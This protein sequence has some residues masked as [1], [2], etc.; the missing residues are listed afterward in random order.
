MKKVIISII[1]LHLV[2][3]GQA[4]QIIGLTN[5]KFKTGDNLEWSKPDYNDVSW[6]TIQAGINWEAEGYAGYDG[7]AWYRIKFYLPSKMK[8]NVLFKDSLMFLLGKIDDRDQTFLNGNIIGQNAKLIRT[9]KNSILQ[10]LSGLESAWDVSRK[11]S[12]STNDVRLKWD[13][14]NVLA[15][16]VHDGG[17][18]GGMYSLPVNIRMENLNDNL[19]FDIE[20]NSLQVKPDGTFNKT[21]TLKNR[22]SLPEIKG[23]L[24]MEITNQDTKKV[25]T[26]QILSVFLKK[27]EVAFTVNFKG[28]RSQRLKASYTFIESKNK[29]SVIHTQKFPYI[30]TPKESETPKINGTKVV[31]VRPG[32]PF[33]YRIPATGIKPMTFTVENLPE[34]LFLETDK[35]IITGNIKQKGDYLIKLKAV[36]TKGETTRN[37]KIVVGDRIALT[38]PMGWNSWNCFGLTVDEEKVK[39]TADIFLKTG[40]ADHGWTYINIDDG[41]EASQ[42]NG[43]GNIAPNGKFKNMKALTDYIH[44]YGLKAGLY[45]SP[46]P[47]TCGN[48]LGSYQHEESDAKMY[49]DWGF[50][51][52]KYDWCSYD[53]IAEDR[54]LIELQK[55]YK[56][57]QLALEKTNRD[58]LFSLCQY[59]MGD[60]WSW[61]DK[62]GGNAWR[63]TGDIIWTWESMSGIGFHQE[64]AAPYAKPGNWNDPDMLVVG[65]VGF[66]NPHPTNLTPDEQYTHISLWSL[67][68]APLLIGCDLTKLD[69]FTLNLLTNDEVIDID[70]DPLGKQAIPVQKTADYQIMVKE[71][72]DGSKA[73]GLFNLTEKDLKIS[74]TWAVLQL[75]GKQ[76]VRDVWR[77]KDLEISGDK[78][79]SI[80]PSHGVMLVRI[81]K[82]VEN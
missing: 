64:A 49:A 19:V 48:Y 55:P 13:K 43:Q 71:M 69:E 40:I 17:G 24:I 37:L 51:Y 29:S 70:Q 68:A 30:L 73:V 12:V 77:Q 79:E 54:S 8:E 76:T 41:W 50:D 10:D 4:Q 67:L 7:Y 15:I 3:V 62:V 60:V 9:G 22:S 18:D 53:Q 11:Y 26:K 46:G 2:F 61:G 25:I 5:W 27:E 78:F 1:F 59:G 75:S 20:S 28:N 58:I 16:R 34:G 52:L 81:S 82:P 66:G 32:S 36:N 44:G 14:E 45:S 33:L 63:T 65:W 80:V 35:G 74:A 31:G 42:R 57:M 6:K 38:P 72:E 47:K 23:R 39:A 56:T 21:F